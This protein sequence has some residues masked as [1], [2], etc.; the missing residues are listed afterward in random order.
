MRIRNFIILSL[1][2]PPSL[3]AQV[4]FEQIT[5]RSVRVVA[6]NTADLKKI[7]IESLKK[8]ASRVLKNSQKTNSEKY[9]QIYEL[10]LSHRLS[11]LPDNILAQV[12]AHLLSP[13]D[14]RFFHEPLDWKYY[15]NWGDLSFQIAA[16]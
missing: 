5:K 8:E 16:T 14:P 12:K 6:R 13:N 4:G 7:D 9:L 1:L 11:I 3:A 10:Y 2:W 15:F